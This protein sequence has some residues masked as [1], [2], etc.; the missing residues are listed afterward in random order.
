MIHWIVRRV[1]LVGLLALIAASVASA[2][3]AT[4][5][6]PETGAGVDSESITANTLKPG[7]CASLDLN[8][9][10]SG[11]GTITDGIASSLIAGS[12]GADTIDGGGGDDCILGG[13][14]D[15][16]I[17]GGPGTDYCIGGGGDDTFDETCEVTEQ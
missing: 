6:V 14:G 5:S 7:E 15:D 13:D 11:S 8:N 12:S 4:N 2:F 16:D 3:A 9:V 1:A 17:S 10:V